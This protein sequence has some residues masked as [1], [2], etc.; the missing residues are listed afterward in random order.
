MVWSITCEDE[1]SVE[2]AVKAPC[3][4]WLAVKALASSL[5]LSSV[6]VQ[7]PLA[8][9]KVNEARVP[10]NFAGLRKTASR[11]SASGSVKAPPVWV[12]S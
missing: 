2:V 11:A 7:E 4:T 9:L 12:T 3:I 8:S 1:P 6:S 5:L 10:L